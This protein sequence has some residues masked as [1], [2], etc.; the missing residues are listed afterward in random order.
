MPKEVI[1]LYRVGPVYIGGQLQENGTASSEAN[2]SFFR[3]LFFQIHAM[4]QS[5]DAVKNSRLRNGR[6]Y[7]Y[8]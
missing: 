3:H 6:P 8:R 5:I 4:T 7:W 2:I 1:K